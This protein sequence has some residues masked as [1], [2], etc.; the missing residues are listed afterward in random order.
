[1]SAGE[2]GLV[3]EN[4]RADQLGDHLVGL[5]TDPV[6]RHTMAAAAR[7]WAMRTFS[8]E[9]IAGQLEGVYADALRTV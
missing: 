7:E 5:L 2:S 3:F 4:D 6:R 8:W 9:V 1:V